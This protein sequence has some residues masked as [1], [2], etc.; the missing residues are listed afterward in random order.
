MVAAELDCLSSFLRSAMARKTPVT[1]SQIQQTAM[2]VDRVSWEK[3]SFAELFSSSSSSI[4]TI[5][6]SQYFKGE[7]AL[8]FTE[9]EIKKTSAPCVLSLIG[10]FFYDRPNMEAIRKAVQTIGLKGSILIGW[11]NRKL[12][13]LRP[14][15]EEDYVCLSLKGQWNILGFR[16]SL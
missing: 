9:E 12:I 1:S 10:K 13:L 3:K 16:M 14:T 8:F 4:S 6:P 11:L 7:P 5:K 2:A 15:L